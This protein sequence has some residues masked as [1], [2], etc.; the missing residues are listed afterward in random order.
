VNG[1]SGHQA[2]KGGSTVCCVSVPAKSASGQNVQVRWG[3][4]NWRDH[5]YSM[6]ERLVPL[7]RCDGP[8]E[9]LWVHFLADGSVRVIDC[10]IG[11][12]VWE[13]N[14]EYPG[15]QPFATTIPRKQPWEDY[16]R[17]RGE[18]EFAGVADSMKDQT[19]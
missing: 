2:G 3:V 12:G 19:H 18:P 7:E 13:P 4:T 8:L 17:A 14:P 15:P 9:H 6:H 11:P 5:T 1:T 10:A 16:P